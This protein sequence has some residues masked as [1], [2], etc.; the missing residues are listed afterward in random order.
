MSE[1]LGVLLMAYGGPDRIEDVEPYLLD[2]RGGRPTPPKVVEEIVRR[3]QRIGGRSP[4][5]E[6]TRAQAAGLQAAFDALGGGYRVAVGMRHWRPSLGEAVACLTAEGV[7]AAVG[8]VMAPH[9]S[10]LSVELY[11]EKLQEAIGDSEA[12]LQVARIDSWHDDSGYLEV[13]EDRIRRG[14]QRFPPEDAGRVELVFTAHSLPE[15]IL[16]WDDPYPRQLRATCQALQARFPDHPAHFAYQSAGMTP[17]PWL[18][19]E[20]G[21]L[22]EARLQAGGR[23][24]LVVPIGFVSEHV[25]VL[26]DIDVDFKER[27]TAAGGRLERIAMPGADP[28]MMASL[29]KRVCQA[30]S[31]KGWS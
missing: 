28:R 18:G 6:G 26:Y 17:E 4:I 12:R 21:R 9:Y 5:L 30:A 29:A 13:L 23:D 1:Q 22:M 11:Y 16:T 2:I 15:R 31:A 27:V 24:F 10:R 8:L 19:P 7:T 14:L 3:Y 20:A 25:E